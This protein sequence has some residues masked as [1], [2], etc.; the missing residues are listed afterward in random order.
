MDTLESED[1]GRTYRFK[2]DSTTL[3][4]VG[5]QGRWHQFE[6]LFGEE[7]IIWAEILDEDLHLL[8]EVL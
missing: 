5:M 4:Y 7:G 2:G 6:E 3:M 8:E 1:I